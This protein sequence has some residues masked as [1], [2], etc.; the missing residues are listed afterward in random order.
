MS[1]VATPLPAV[2]SEP[3]PWRNRLAFGLGTLGRDMTAA[4][5][6][7]FLMFYLSDVLD[8]SEPV[9]AAVTVILVVMRI[10]DAVNDPFMG[11]VVDNTRSRW[12]KFKPWI[13]VGALLWGLTTVLMFVDTG[14]RGT[15]FL[16][17]FTLVYLAWEISYTIND[18]SFYGLLPSLTR[19]QKEREA[20][21]V[22]ARICANI[23]LFAVVVAIVPITTMLGERL[24]SLQQGWLV[25][26]VILVVVMLAFQSLTVV[27]ARQR[28]AVPVEHTPLRD[29]ARVIGKNDQLLWVTLAMVIFMA[30]YTATTSLGIY[31]FKYVYRDEGM[32]SIFAAILGVAQLTGLAVFPLVAKV[33][34]RRAIH[35]LA[36]VLCVG[37]LLVFALAAQDMLVIG[38]AGVLLFVGQAFIQLL[39]LMFVADCV[40]YGEWK[41]GRRN[42]SVTFSLQPFIY[43]GSN[44]LGTALVGL[45]LL[46][47]GISRIASPSEM[48]EAGINNFKVVMMIIP[49]ILM[50]I[51][52]VILRAKYRI[53]EPRYAAIV[54][55]LAAREA[56][57]T[58]N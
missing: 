21:G 40:E 37:G 17:V 1:S 10:F 9:L 12:G 41:L 31:Y 58:A 45:A 44:A 30:G 56:R 4:M 46:W 39:M 42:E 8:V 29:L 5:V 32:Y 48:T 38:V 18:I 26:S 54:A 28:V 16:V 43:K 11:V 24:G 20:I 50:I 55:E 13:A 34:S 23:G 2:E 49:L 52:W 47:S 7:M 35:L 3:R 15:A 36:T 22:I 25:L 14:L 51:S 57:T 53:D 6:S 19:N 27:F 33:L